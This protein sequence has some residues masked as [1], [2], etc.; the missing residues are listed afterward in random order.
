[1]RTEAKQDERSIAERVGVSIANF[2]Q[3]IMCAPR[4]LVLQSY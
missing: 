3:K 2:Q 1:M 4:V